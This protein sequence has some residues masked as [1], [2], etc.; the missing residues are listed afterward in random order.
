MKALDF[1]FGSNLSLTYQALNAV[2]FL[3]MEYLKSI[4]ARVCGSAARA[5]GVRQK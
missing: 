4:Y 1:Y 5:K 3:W 2:F